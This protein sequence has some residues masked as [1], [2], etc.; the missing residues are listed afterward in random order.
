M[1]THTPHQDRPR[2]P[3]EPTPA[4][5]LPS[6]LKDVV[7]WVLRYGGTCRD[8]ADENGNCPCDGLPCADREKPIRFV[9]EALRYGI[10]HGY[11]APFYAS[12]EPTPASGEA[13]PGE[14]V[15]KLVVPEHCTGA[16]FVFE[17]GALHVNK[18]GSGY[19]AVDEDQWSI[20]DDRCE[21]PDGPQG[22]TQW[23]ARLPKGELESLRDFLNGV[24]SI[25]GWVC[26]ARKSSGPND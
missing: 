22:S 10:A 7:A 5:A 20:E 19:I 3:G 18:D 4:K 17:P 6:D 12:Q 15:A 14:A 9:G 11:V 1:T 26:V 24:Q 21:G 8:C 13:E 2:A 25:S 23:I 16:T